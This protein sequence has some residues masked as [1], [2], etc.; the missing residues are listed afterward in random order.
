MKILSLAAVAALAALATTPALAK[1]QR[2][3]ISMQNA[4]ARALAVVPH[5]RIKSGEL[6]TEHGQLLYSFDIQ[7]AN[8]PGIEEVQISAL[9]GRL[10]SRTH[11]SAAAERREQRTEAREHKGH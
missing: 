6:E 1:P 7:V 8:R 9:D 2:P 3:H 4:R 5:G 11:E 10:L